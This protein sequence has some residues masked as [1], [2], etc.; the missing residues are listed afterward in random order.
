[1]VTNNF[2]TAKFRKF[3]R[4]CMGRNPYKNRHWA[5][6]HGS[7]KAAVCHSS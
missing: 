6:L 4:C 1:M 5:L 3:G 2:Y 7:I